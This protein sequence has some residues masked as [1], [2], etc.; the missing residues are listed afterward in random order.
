MLRNNKLKKVLIT[1]IALI[2]LLGT[3]A[4]AA[5]NISTK[6]L[7]ATIG[8][9]KFNVNGKDVTNQIESKYGTP[10]F[11]VNNRSYVPVRAIA[12]LMGLKVEYDDITHTAKITDI[13]SAEYEKKLK[14][15]DDEIAKL[16]K[17]LA[18]LKKNVVDVSDLKDLEKDL[19]KEFGTYKNVDFDISLKENKN[20]IDV[21]ITVNL[22]T[23]R[24][25]SYWNKMYNSRND[26][27]DM[28]EDIVGDIAKEFK[29]TK[30]IGDI[31][32]EYDNKALVTFTKNKSSSTV[33]ISY[34]G[35]ST[36]ERFYDSYI[37]DAVEDEFAYYYI[38]DAYLSYL[39]VSSYAVEMDITF[40]NRYAREWD[41]LS[42]SQKANMLDRIADEVNYDYPDYDVEMDIYIGNSREGIYLREYD[43]KYGTFR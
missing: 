6:Q 2:L 9:I 34:K 4:V 35:V 24:E 42:S 14:E 15:K 16:N 1:T 22:K 31:Y 25:R 39:D 17:E 37:E 10:A 40:S 3:A 33:T 30:I 12:E 26:L 36:G 7:T 19:N 20:D 27:K 8:R 18:D 43:S 38:Y 32:D 13:K 21:S 23:S 29:N 11:V 41:D 5:E 28:I